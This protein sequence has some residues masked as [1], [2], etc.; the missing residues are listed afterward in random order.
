MRILIAYYKE[1]KLQCEIQSKDRKE[2]TDA[3]RNR[4]DKARARDGPP[5]MTDE[6]KRHI[7]KLSEKQMQIELKFSRNALPITNLPSTKP[8]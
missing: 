6:W 1:Y 8:T 5:P 3:K 4:I 7:S 2:I